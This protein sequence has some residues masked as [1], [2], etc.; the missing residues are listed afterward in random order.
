MRDDKSKQSMKPTPTK[1]RHLFFDLDHTLWDFDANAK[2][3]L[4]EIYLIFELESKFVSP[5]EFFYST[6]LKHNAIL[7]DRFEKGYITSE[8]LKWKRMW[9]TLMDFRIGDEKL[10]KE[11]SAKFLEILPTKKR[12]FDYTFEILDYLTEKNYS[13]HLITNGFEKTQ[14]SK[15]NNSLL[16]KYFT[17]VIT[18]ET[19]NSMKPQKEIFEYALK[20]TNGNIEECIMIGD[21]LNADIQGA[22]NAGMDAIF[23][24]HIKAN[25]SIKP[26]HTVYH[27]KELE[28]IL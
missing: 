23:V 25:H 12:V 6:Y 27:L 15:L 18:S 28:S 13:I 26:T 22:L 8:E 19:S 2:E 1:Y 7:W 3:S 14:W 5:F 11:M 9:R 10:A 17:H 20:K 24:N 21:N 16:A 4:A